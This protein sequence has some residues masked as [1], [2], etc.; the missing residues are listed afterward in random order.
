VGVILTDDAGCKL[1]NALTQPDAADVTLIEGGQMRFN[2]LG[3]HVPKKRLSLSIETE[4][5]S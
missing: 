2:L 1:V 5:E 4:M 3:V